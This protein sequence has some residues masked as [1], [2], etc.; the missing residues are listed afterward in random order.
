MTAK[1][2]KVAWSKMIK[3]NDTKE[4]QWTAPKLKLALQDRG[5]ATPRGNKSALFLQLLDWNKQTFGCLDPSIALCEADKLLARWTPE[6][7]RV[8]LF[9][10]EQD[11]LRDDS[12]A[13]LFDQ[14]L[15]WDLQ[16]FPG[17]DSGRKR[18]GS[19]ATRDGKK[20][21]SASMP[22]TPT[23]DEELSDEE[24]DDVGRNT[25]GKSSARKEKKA[26]AATRS[27]TKA[28]KEDLSS[29]DE[30][31]ELMLVQSDDED[32]D[33]EQ[34]ESFFVGRYASPKKV[35]Q[36]KKTDSLQLGQLEEH[37]DTWTD[38]FD[39]IRKNGR[40]SEKTRTLVHT[41]IE[42][43][44]VGN[45]LF[46]YYMQAWYLYWV[47]EIKR[48]GAVV[49]LMSYDKKSKFGDDKSA[50]FARCKIESKQQVTGLS[51]DCIA[52]FR[53]VTT[54]DSAVPAKWPST[55]YAIQE[56]MKASAASPQ[57]SKASDSSFFD[58]F[59]A[60]ITDDDVI[61]GASK[62]NTPRGNGLTKRAA[63]VLSRDPDRVLTTG[64]MVMYNHLCYLPASDDTA[65]FWGIVQWRCQLQP[66]HLLS[67]VRNVASIDVRLC[68]NTR[69]VMGDIDADAICHTLVR[70]DEKVADYSAR[71]DILDGSLE[72]T[73]RCLRMFA[74]TIDVIFRLRD[75]IRSVIQTA[76]IRIV[77]FASRLCI[78][79]GHRLAPLMHHF[80]VRDFQLMMSQAMGP[81]LGEVTSDIKGLIRTIAD[82]PDMSTFSQFATDV[83]YIR[84]NSALPAS[85]QMAMI[86]PVK[87]KSDPRPKKD[88]V[89]KDLPK[90]G[91]TGSSSTPAQGVTPA[92]NNSPTPKRKP[93]CG[94]FNTIDGC[95]ETPDR[96]R[97]DHRDPQ[98]EADE[99]SLVN[100][101][102]RFKKAVRKH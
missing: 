23:R 34:E 27:K 26:K 53:R 56:P 82:Y 101:F 40:K 92:Q 55:V 74:M 48:D 41:T 54:P 28:N 79:T 22:K 87:P 39:N 50:P 69:D 16:N 9:F 57:V 21:K 86:T 17:K 25:R 13:A 58:A 33:D 29:E 42:N 20:A 78:S 52:Y 95:K 77:T 91:S 12:K 45:V 60:A 73:E 66:A 3:F 68:A 63:G 36:A 80:L 59:R 18:S 35:T 11:F 89:K 46:L 61:S 98:S 44:K 75:E 99:K 1:T 81:V 64:N 96:C 62:K 97:G 19:D 6:Q 84:T 88:L 76:I 2:N 72:R 102:H 47:R 67:L 31:E 90:N 24:E 4:S 15:A 5:I 70:H 14:L 43:C 38:S 71:L 85:M 51:A 32:D 37:A 94:F 49:D 30:E 100:F 8:A 7:L 10:R 65:V 93:I 83:Q